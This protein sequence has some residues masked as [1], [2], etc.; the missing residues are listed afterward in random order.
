[1][2]LEVEM[3]FPVAD[4][5]ALADRLRER[6]AQLDKTLHEE[7]HYFNAPDRNFAQTDEALR[8]RRIGAANFVT[9]KGPKRDAETKTRAEIEVPLAEGDR[10]AADFEKLLTC[11]GYRPVAVVRKQ[12]RT[13]H[14]TED[15]FSVEICL[16]EVEDVGRF[17]ELELVVPEER[18]EEARAVL[19]RLARELGL[20]GSERRSYLEMLLSKDAFEKRR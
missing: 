8:L 4:L 2:M 11:L 12:R 6:G 7:D 15:T 3:K 1:M 14:L 9:Y 16:D 5:D 20:S 17:A 13:L 19:L 18:L 10:A